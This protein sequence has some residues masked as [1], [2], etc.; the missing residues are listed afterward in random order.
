MF[1]DDAVGVVETGAALHGL[2]KVAAPHLSSLSRYGTQV[3]ASMGRMFAR[4]AHFAMT[5]A[6]EMALLLAVV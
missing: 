4:A 5:D 6:I 2:G 3:A 1:R